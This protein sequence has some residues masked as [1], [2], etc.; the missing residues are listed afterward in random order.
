MTVSEILNETNTEVRM[1]EIGNDTNPL[2]SKI[3]QR[4]S[5]QF[6][7]L[8]NQQNSASGGKTLAAMNRAAATCQLCHGD[9][10]TPPISSFHSVFREFIISGRRSSTPRMGPRSRRKTLVNKRAKRT[11]DVAVTT[12]RLVVLPVS[13]LRE[14]PKPKKP[15]RKVTPE[16]CSQSA[17]RP[18]LSLQ[19]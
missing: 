11:Q 12:E 1:S 19:A 9:P 18:Q 5:H 2:M 8:E 13:S 16:F 10:N 14:R 6:H 4:L 15:A 3:L 7:R 17:C